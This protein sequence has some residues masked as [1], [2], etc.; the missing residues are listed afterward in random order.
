[1]CLIFVDIWEY[2]T[3]NEVEN[4]PSHWLTSQDGG[5]PSCCCEDGGTS[6]ISKIGV[7]PVSIMGY[8]PH[9]GSR[10]GWR[11]Y[12]QPEQDGVYLLC[13][14]CVTNITLYLL[15]MVLLSPVSS[16]SIQA[17][18]SR[19]WQQLSMCFLFVH[20]ATIWVKTE[21]LHCTLSL[22]G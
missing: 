5:T 12:T 6:L 10:S 2:F 3:E 16:C 13:G 17:S 11:G 7:L 15:S 21:Q 14:G 22:R 4:P 20:W 18:S 1:M 9:S 8:H 19:G